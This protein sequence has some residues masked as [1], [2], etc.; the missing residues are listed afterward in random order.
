M[1]SGASALCR[2]S[3]TG[4]A[5]SGRL[6]SKPPDAVGAEIAL[7]GDGMAFLAV[8]AGIVLAAIAARLFGT[9]PD[10]ADCAARPRTVEQA[11]GRRGGD[12]DAARIDR[13]HRCRIQLSRCPPTSTTPALGSL[14]GT[15]AMTLPEVPVPRSAGVSVSFSVIG[16]PRAAIRSIW[17]PSETDSAAAGMGAVPAGSW[18]RR[19]A[20][21]DGD[22]CRSI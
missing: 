7:A 3:A 5:L 21:C 4:F 15:S 13:S 1:P 6:T 10:D 18:C 16:L 17:S 19:C 20:G 22:R 8:D 12:R 14:P 9:E 2:R 11:L